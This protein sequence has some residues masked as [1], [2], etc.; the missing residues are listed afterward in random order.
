MKRVLFMQLYFGNIRGVSGVF[1][2]PKKK[3]IFS[4]AH[5]EDAIRWTQRHLKT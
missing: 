4:L 1:E 2:V 5:D 3:K